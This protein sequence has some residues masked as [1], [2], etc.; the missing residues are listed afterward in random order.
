MHLD[1]EVKLIQELELGGLLGCFDDSIGQVNGPLPSQCV[2]LTDNSIGSSY[3]L[4]RLRS[5]YR[6]MSTGTRY[7]CRVLF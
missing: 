2:M 7:R 4:R 1:G 6:P 3:I 5:S